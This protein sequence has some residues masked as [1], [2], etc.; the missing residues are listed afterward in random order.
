VFCCTVCCGSVADHPMPM[1]HPLLKRGGCQMQLFSNRSP[2]LRLWLL[3]AGSQTEHS[4]LLNSTSALIR[5][6]RG[7]PGA[8]GGASDV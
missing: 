4:M 8:Q 5:A 1:H 2:S 6:F 3:K 7:L